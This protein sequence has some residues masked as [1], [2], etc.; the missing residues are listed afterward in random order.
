MPQYI[1]F[2]WDNGDCRFLAASVQK[3][4][5]T[6]RSYGV[7]AAENET[8]DTYANFSA[9]V[10]KI[11][12]EQ[13]I[14]NIPAAVTLG[15]TQIDWLYQHLPLC[16]ETE[17]PVLL[18]N[19]VLRELPNFVDFDPLDY[20]LL[21]TSADGEQLLAVTVQLSFRQRLSR[22]L[23]NSKHPLQRLGFRAVDAAAAAFADTSLW[24]TADSGSKNSPVTLIVNTVGNDADLILAVDKKIRSIR[25]FRLAE[26]N[27]EQGLAE[28]IQ[29]TLTIG[30]EDAAGLP[31][32]RIVLFGTQN[33]LL[34][35]LSELELEVVAVDLEKYALSNSKPEYAPLLGSLLTLKDKTQFKSQTG[36]DLL[37]P[38]K[39]P[40]PPNYIRPIILAL[41]FLSIVGY[42]VYHWNRGVVQGLENKLAEIKKEHQNVAGELQ[43]IQPGWN[44]LRQTQIWESQNVLWLDVLKELS[45]KLPGG[46]D[47]VV[48]Q[49]TFSAG[50]AGANQRIRGTITMSG[51]VRDPSVLLKLQNDLRLTGQYFMQN[52][53]P[54]PNPAG[55]GYPWLFKASVYRF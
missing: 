36:I 22:A 49:M 5:L 43:A 40:E 52:P 27:R 8:E 45:E 51:M 33:P 50:P 48:S 7:V 31:V 21:N 28:E 34:E 19:Q 18:K 16:K 55:G 24:E 10:K 13:K 42:G 44:V 41:L 12:Q 11:C 37:H 39:A 53:A 2:D 38:K 17:I 54:V 46:T 6:V 3:D 25:S 15:R 30:F 9:A 4:I 23:K 29:R 26:Q 14:G 1:A 32:D 20:L 35:T 47:L